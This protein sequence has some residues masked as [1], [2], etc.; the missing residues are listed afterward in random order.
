[1]GQSAKSVV[2]LQLRKNPRRPETAAFDL[3][4]FATDLGW[5][6]VWGIQ[7]KVVSLCFGHVSADEVRR[8]SERLTCEII[9]TKPVAEHDW[10]PD[11][12]RR[13]QQFAAGLRVDFAAVEIKL[14]PLSDFQ[15]RVVAAVRRVS[16]GETV[17]Y[18]QL[19]SKAGF[20]GAARAVGSVMAANRIPII[21]PCHRV[22]AAGNKLGGFSSPRGVQMKQRLLDMEAQGAWDRHEARKVEG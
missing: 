7:G 18:G 13:L 2:A 22:V 20:P 16:Y 14:P 6:G 19:A 4:L 10:T 8:D 5:F 21:V 9:E 17:T 12:R 11:L 3:S 1:M 15:N